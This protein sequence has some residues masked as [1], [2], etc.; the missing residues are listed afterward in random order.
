MIHSS[1]TAALYPLN[2]FL[3]TRQWTDSSRGIVLEFWFSTERGPVQ[4]IIDSQKAVFFIRQ[5]DVERVRQLLPGLATLEIKALALKD[6]EQQ[7]VS[8]VYFDSQQAL[9]QA[10]D[11]LRQQQIKHYEADIRPVDRYLMERF[12]TGPVTLYSQSPWQAHTNHYRL[13]PRIKARQDDYA[14][15]PQLRVISLDIETAYDSNELYSI[16]LLAHHWRL[17][18]MKGKPVAG[19]DTQQYIEYCPDEARLLLRFIE[20]INEQDP[21]IIIGWNVVNFDFRMLQRKADQLKLSL[22]IGRNESLILWRKAQTEQSHYFLLIPGRVVLDGISTLKSATW[23]FPGFSLEAVSNELL[24]RGKLIKSESAKQRDPLHKA[25]A[26]KTLFSKDKAA[27]AAYNMEDCQLVW[28]IFQKTDLIAFAIERTRLTGLEMDRSGGSVA[29]FDNLYLPRL[30]R[31][32]YV[33]PNLDDRQENLSAP[34]GYVMNSRPGLYDSVL[35]LDFK[36]LYPSIIRTF[37][38]DP[39]AR[40]RAEILAKKDCIPGFNGV[41]FARDDAILPDIIRALWQ[42]RDRAKQD[43]NKPLSQ[44]I[45]IIM[46]SFYGVLGTPGCRIHDA[47]LTSSIT[48]RGHELMQQTT[49]LI[50]AEGYQVIYGDTDSVFVALGAAREQHYADK[51]GKQLVDTINNYWHHELKRVYD[52]ES[53]LEMEYET[54]YMRFFMP[55]IRGSDKGSKKRYAGLIAREAGDQPARMVFK[56]LET[57]RSDWT[58][59]AR[60]VQQELYSRVFHNKPYS[61][62]LQEIVWSLRAGKLD[63]LLVYRKRLR[64]KLSDYKKNRPP[65]A[66]AALKAQQYAR[67]AADKFAHNYENAGWIEYVMTY[68]GAEPLQ[69]NQQPLDYEHYIDKQLAPVADAILGLMGTSLEKITQ[70]QYELF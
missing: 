26:I 41:S 37:K 25:K 61:D 23:N 46:N 53:Y 28:D 1:E 7:A 13:N 42:A 3:L 16:S 57:V 55:T 21:D 38:V 39:Y 49:Q 69:Y 51:T 60:T 17:T 11:C 31:K 15:Q 67:A 44:T 56:G 58:E 45:K 2:A 32:G 29:A 27:L 14:Y 54:H 59:L 48:L 63:H 70:A 30:H 35:V 22:T 19:D 20:L 68:S 43:N 24:G 34:G 6:F 64:Q 40:V 18:L 5:Q 33:A 10:R 62:Y 47:R 4:V 8:A 66:Q 65:H 52:I 9:Y 50:Q 12:I 36:S